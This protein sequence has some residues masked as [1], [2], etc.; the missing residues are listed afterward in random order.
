MASGPLSIVSPEKNL[1]DDGDPISPAGLPT[2]TVADSI[3]AFADPSQTL[4]FVDWD[5]TLFPTSNIFDVWG[6][7][8]RPERWDENVQFTLEQQQKLDQWREALYLYLRTAC[9]LTNRLTIVTNARRPWVRQCIDFFAPALQLHFDKEEGCPVIVYAQE[10][11]AGK[12]DALGSRRGTPVKCADPSDPRD[13]FEEKMMKAK[14]EAMR[15]EA[16]AFYSQYPDQT[17]KNIISV[18]DARYEHDAAQ[19][20]AWR[21]RSPDRERLRIKTLIS[22]SSPSIA[23]L[24]YRLRL[25][26]LLW[27][28]YVK[29]D[30]DLD[31]D[32]NTPEGLRVCAEALGLPELKSVIRPQLRDCKDTVEE[33]DAITW[34]LD[35]VAVAVQHAF[36]R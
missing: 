28:A 35:E 2:P 21:R 26:T 20:L 7:P 8:S 14:F 29:Y 15:K 17:W 11:L 4:I 9:S 31:F 5:D 34:E 3:L 6:V 27:P 22:P 32:M 19:E 25:Q 30:G 16:S 10:A 13:V 33:E 24:T 23:A 18:G 36:E 1:N 12:R